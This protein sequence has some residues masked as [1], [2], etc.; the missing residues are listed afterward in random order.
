MDLLPVVH[1]WYWKMLLESGFTEAWLGKGD[2]GQARVS[3]ER[4]LEVT[5]QTSE[6]TWQALAWD[7]IARVAM[8]QHDSQRA[9]VCTTNALTAM[10]GYEVPLAHWRVHGTAFELY[11]RMEDKKAAEEHRQL[12]C[13]TIMKLA[14][15]MP[16]GEPLRETF[17]S[18]PAI[19]RILTD[20][21]VSANPG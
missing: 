21:E 20:E 9:Q 5:Q 11:E 13:A 6:H 4:F 3:A 1:D 18:A 17:L 10:E 12:S 19:R 14:N 2:L 15:S 8:A 16:T 7:A